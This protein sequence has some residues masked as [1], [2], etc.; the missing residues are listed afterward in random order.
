MD[1]EIRMNIQYLMKKEH[2][3][4]IRTPLNSKYIKLMYI[5]EL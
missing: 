3:I 1:T 2:D 5:L 4:D